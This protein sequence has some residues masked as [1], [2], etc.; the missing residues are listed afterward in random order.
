MNGI[1]NAI[2]VQL[3]NS[4]ICGNIIYDTRTPPLTQ[5]GIFLLG[6]ST[7]VI[8]SENNI[9]RMTSAGIFLLE[10][11]DGMTRISITQNTIYNVGIGYTYSGIQVDTNIG[12][13]TSTHI[14]SYFN[15][16]SN[17]TQYCIFYKNVLNSNIHF[18]DMLNSLSGNVYLTGCTGVNVTL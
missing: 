2:D 6:P 17:T 10:N 5:N 7:D 8:I 15:M 13:E 11:D 14:N 4:E 3:F 18:N 1:D 9:R 12:T 16:I